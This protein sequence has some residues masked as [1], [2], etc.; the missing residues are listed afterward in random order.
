MTL[1][2]TD[3]Y[4]RNLKPQDGRYDVR[5]GG[6]FGVRVFPSGEKSWI[7]L[8]T[9]LGKKRRLTLGKYPTLSLREARTAYAEAVHL[10]GQGKDPA[11][12]LQALRDAQRREAEL[13]RKEPSIKALVQEYLD[14]WA[15]PRKRSWKEDQRILNKD[16]IPVWGNYK[17]KEIEQRDVVL[18]LDAIKNRGADIQANRT[19]AVIRRMFNFAIERGLLTATPVSHV[20]PVKKETPR[21]RVLTPEEIRLFWYGLDTAP[22]S[23]P[24]RLALRLLLVTGQRKGEVLAMEWSELDTGNQWWTIPAAKAKNGHQHRVPLS[25]PAIDILE[26]LRTL[27]LSD[28]KVFASPRHAKGE[29][30]TGQAVDHALRRCVFEGIT[31]FT[32]HD[33]RRTVGTSLGKL[34]FNRLVQDKVLNHKDNTVGGIYDRH[35]YDTEKRQALNA[36][37]DHLHAI[38]TGEAKPA[39]VLALKRQ[40]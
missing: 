25:A 37:A 27:S 4:I 39:N 15:R 14:G 31:P 12:Y 23:L 2:F 30:I 9:Y 8:Y 18:L 5:E 22:M 11:V 24:V 28:T 16:I 34:G 21:D 7:Y 36:W 6:G 3:V 1:R 26:Q 32:P 35:S 20:K 38:L 17:A 29:P 19:L 13:A 40:P 10:L 33:L